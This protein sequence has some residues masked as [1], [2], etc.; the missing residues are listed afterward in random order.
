VVSLARHNDAIP[1]R[2]AGSGLYAHKLD[3]TV[4]RVAKHTVLAREVPATLGRRTTRPRLRTD[5]RKRVGCDGGG[6]EREREEEG[7]GGE[8]ACVVISQDTDALLL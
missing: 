1:R 4:K 2:W 6:E 3:D 7:L 8:H 5:T